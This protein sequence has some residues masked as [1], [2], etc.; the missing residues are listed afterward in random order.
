M[1]LNVA[2]TR[3]LNQGPAPDSPDSL[4]HVQL[5]LRKALQTVDWQLGHRPDWGPVPCDISFRLTI[6]PTPPSKDEARFTGKDG[7]DRSYAE[8][9]AWLAGYYYGQKE[10]ERKQTPTSSQKR[11]RK[12]E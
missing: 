8:H 6:K 10:F 4:R 3:W 7:V 2:Y 1:V 9:E 5:V 11:A 12:N